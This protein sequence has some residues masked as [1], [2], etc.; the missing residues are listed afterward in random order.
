VYSD[1]FTQFTEAL[2]DDFDFDKACELAEVMVKEA[3][4]DILLRPHAKEIRRSA[5]LY[6]FEV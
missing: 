5:L 1:S 3:E 2:F 4:N 6:V